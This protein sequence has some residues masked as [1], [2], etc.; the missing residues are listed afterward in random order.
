MSSRVELEIQRFQKLTLAATSDPSR[1]HLTKMCAGAQ[2]EYFSV[3]KKREGRRR[4]AP[5]E[6]SY[7]CREDEPCVSAFVAVD[8]KAARI[9]AF[10][11][12]QLCLASP[13]RL[14]SELSGVVD[15]QVVTC[16]SPGQ[17]SL[18]AGGTHHHREALRLPMRVIEHGA[19][20]VNKLRC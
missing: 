1:G 16:Q 17:D 15:V 12:R 2:P 13:V 7:I 19:L 8:L 5:K 14:L 3:G 10:W 6:A 20:E 4:K 9:T 11:N 18:D